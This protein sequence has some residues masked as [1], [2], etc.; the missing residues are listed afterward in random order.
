MA[1]GRDQHPIITQLSTASFLWSGKIMHE[2]S[3]LSNIKLEKTSEVQGLSNHHSDVKMSAMAS[4]I[5]AVSIAYPTVCSGA[6]QSKHKSP[7]I[8][9][10]C[11]GN[12]PVTGGF[13]SQRAS[14]AENV[15]FRWRHHPSDSLR[16]KLASSQTQL[17][18]MVKLVSLGFQRYHMW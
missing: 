2:I 13:P 4:Q 5:T 8:T 10:L 12:P 9:G 17:Y 15:S 18:G 1:Y 6:D 3:T 16:G 7:R 14:D 11:E